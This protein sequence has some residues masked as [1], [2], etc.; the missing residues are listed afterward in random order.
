MPDV[1]ISLVDMI[2]YILASVVSD[3]RAAL[4]ERC[5][6]KEFVGIV[7]F[8]LAQFTG[9]YRGNHDHRILSRKRKENYFYPNNRLKD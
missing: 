9:T 7:V 3:S 1:H 2:R 4:R 5:F 6:I 8:R